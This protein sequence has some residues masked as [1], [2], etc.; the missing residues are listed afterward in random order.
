MKGDFHIK[1]GNALLA[2]TLCVLC[3]KSIVANVHSDSGSQN[4]YSVIS[5]TLD[6]GAR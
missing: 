5:I 3:I 1:T 6:H 2:L 4:S